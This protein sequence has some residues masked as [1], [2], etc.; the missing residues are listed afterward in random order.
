[1]RVE[2]LNVLGAGDAFMS[3]FLSGWLRDASDARCCQLANACGGLVVSRHACAPAMPTPAELE[4]LFNSPVPI[5]RPDQ[6]VALQR[7][8]QVSV[9]RKQWKQ[10]FIFAFDHR[11]QLFELAQQGGADSQ[12][13]SE[14]KMLFIQAVQRV[15]ADLGQRGV[16]ADVGCWPISA[17]A[18]TPSMPP[19]AVA[20][21]SHARW[22][23]KA[24]GRW[25]S[26]TGARSAAT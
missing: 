7:L 10:L 2:V 3:G 11:G 5:T 12:R 6:D 20:G 23:A 1:V 8:H 17:S 22:S 25:R 9:P 15:E 21:G 24:R 4:Y 13:I 26:N 18:R 16:D 19:P 14:L